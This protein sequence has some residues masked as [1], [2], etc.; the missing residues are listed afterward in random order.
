M[1]KFRSAHRTVV[2]EIK[3]FVVDTISRSGV[4]RQSVSARV[5][6]D[7]EFRKLDVNVSKTQSYTIDSTKAVF[8]ILSPEP[9]RLVMTQTEELVP[10]EPAEPEEPEYTSGQVVAPE[11]LIA[12]HD[13]VVSVVDP[14]PV[15]AQKTLDVV[16][17]N[18]DT[19][20]TESLTLNRSAEDTFVGALKTVN[21]PDKGTDFDS[22]MNVQHDQHI[23]VIY[24]DHTST[25]GD[26]TS[27]EQSVTIQSPYSDSQISTNAYIFPGKP[28]SVVVEDADL[29]GQTVTTAQAINDT[30]GEVETVYLAETEL[31]VFSGKVDTEQYD[32]EESY[33]SDDG[34]LS[35][36]PGDSVRVAFTDDLFVTSGEAVAQVEIRESSNVNGIIVGPTE[37]VVGSSVSV[38]LS[39]YNR[40]GTA[41][42]DIPVSNVRTREYEMVTLTENIP[43]TGIFSGN[44]QLK[45]GVSANNDGQLGVEEGDTV[46]VVYIDVSSE[47]GNPERISHDISIVGAQ[48][49]VAEPEP[50]KTPVEPEPS[51]TT[52]GV[53][54]M[55]INGMFFLNGRF[56]GKIRVVGLRDDLTR[57]S[58]LSV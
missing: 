9:V 37:T 20:E 35:V 38:T 10:N 45:A 54:E 51:N 30:T 57:C 3:S 2:T 41:S 53:I 1:S 24:R 16:V 19:G 55:E 32:S 27:V 6:D 48:P 47:S 52:S 46:Q 13:L 44:F 28:I 40:S 4:F 5:P 26:V 15:Q 56:P 11:L 39:D 14:D 17:F 21:A 33:L 8:A 29:S 7:S 22:S 12:G 34:T 18:S 58:L 23:R 31:G 36:S 49:V 43:D 25:S 50:E 42:I